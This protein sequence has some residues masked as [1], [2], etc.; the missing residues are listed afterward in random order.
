[1]GTSGVSRAGSMDLTRATRYV[2]VFAGECF[3]FGIPAMTGPG[4]NAAAMG[5]RQFTPIPQTG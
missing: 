4:F 3:R 1:M 2:L 5:Y